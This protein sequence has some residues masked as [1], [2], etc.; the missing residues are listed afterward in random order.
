M[1]SFGR[2]RRTKVS[3]ERTRGSHRRGL[4]RDVFRLA[5]RRTRCSAVAP[6]LG[7]SLAVL[8]GWRLVA[9]T[10]DAS[11]ARI[12]SYSEISCLRMLVIPTCCTHGCASGCD[13]RLSSRRRISGTPQCGV[14]SPRCDRRCSSLV[15]RDCGIRMKHGSSPPPG[16]SASFCCLA[17]ST[18]QA[19]TFRR[20][21]FARPCAATPQLGV[22]RS[23]AA[24]SFFGQLQPFWIAPMSVIRS[25]LAAS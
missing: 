9:H 3:E 20:D 2:R 7:E 18:T 15:M 23:R 22:H 16:G 11:M 12:L 25:N 19:W 13:L 8:I 17:A 21:G 10:T 14:A 6:K 24:G 5:A 4:C 1:K